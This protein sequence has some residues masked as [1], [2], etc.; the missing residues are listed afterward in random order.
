VPGTYG[1]NLVRLPSLVV[2]S[3]K[4]ETRRR[5]LVRVAQSSMQLAQQ[6]RDPLGHCFW[7]LGS[8]GEFAGDSCLH[9]LDDHVLAPRLQVDQQ[10]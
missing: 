4:V 8:R 6:V 3:V 7:N 5:L 9:F 1:K 10:D 2:R